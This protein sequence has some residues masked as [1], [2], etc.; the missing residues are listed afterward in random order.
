MFKG[1]VIGPF[2][3]NEEICYLKILNGRFWGKRG[4]E[5]GLVA[6]QSFW[7]FKKGARALSFHSNEPYRDIFGPLG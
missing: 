7:S 1:I 2:N 5:G 3:Y 4:R 6:L